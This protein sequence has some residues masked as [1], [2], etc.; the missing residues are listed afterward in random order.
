MDSGHKPG[1]RK[2]VVAADLAT[3]DDARSGYAANIEAGDGEK[4]IDL[5]L[6]PS[7]AD[8]DADI[9]AGPLLSRGASECLSFS[10]AII[11]G[12]KLIDDY[13]VF[14]YGRPIGRIMWHPQA[15]KDRPW[16]WT[17]TARSQPPSVYNR[18][19]CA[20][21]EQAMADFKTRLAI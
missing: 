15:P 6:P 2:L 5:I 20:T 21:R 17:I 19:Y 18:G 3:T 13:E 7:R 16:F 11:C 1:A 9:A 14:A 12:E 10:N 8:V 4:V